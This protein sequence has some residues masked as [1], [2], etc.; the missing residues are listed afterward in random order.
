MEVLSKVRVVLVT[1]PDGTHIN[2]VYTN[3]VTDESIEESM[4]NDYGEDWESSY[5]T[6]EIC[7]ETVY[8]K[9]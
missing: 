5:G 8:L 2:G 9:P 6:I 3:N 1:T 4:V 7:D